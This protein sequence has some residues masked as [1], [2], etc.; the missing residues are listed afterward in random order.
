VYATDERQARETAARLERF[1][2]VLTLLTR[3]SPRPDSRA[4]PVYLVRSRD[5]I[6]RLRRQGMTPGTFPTGYYSASPTGMLLA[7]DLEWDLL[8][9]HTP[10]KTDVWLFEKY[11]R[12]FIARSEQ[13]EIC[14]TGMS[15]ASRWSWPPCNFT[16]TGSTMALATPI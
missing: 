11:T 10:S 12:H 6:A 16:R 14:P 4:I 7:A 1:H 5:E 15:P 8:Y 2:Q 3:S 9:P 13:G